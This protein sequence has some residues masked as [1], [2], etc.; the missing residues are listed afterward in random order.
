[1]Q[2]AAVRRQLPAMFSAAPRHPGA[3]GVL[4]MTVC[5]CG[6]G[7]QEVNG[8]TGTGSGSPKVA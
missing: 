5:V 1:M 3:N 2:R 4:P 7:N 6:G 8:T